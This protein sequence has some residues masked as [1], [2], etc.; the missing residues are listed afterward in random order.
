MSLQQRMEEIVS[1]SYRLLC[2]RIACRSIRVS[3][4]AALQLHFGTILK[5]VGSLYEFWPTSKFSIDLEKQFTEI[6][7]SK[8]NGK[9]RCDIF[10]TLESQK[11][12]VC[13]AIEL[14]YFPKSEGETTTDNRFAILEDIENIEHYKAHEGP[15]TGY[16]IVFTTNPNYANPN[17]R[18][19]INIGEGQ[20]IT[21]KV[22]CSNNK[23]AVDLKGSYTFHWDSLPGNCYFLN[24]KF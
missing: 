17:T 2:Q 9:A 1:T 20:T 4:E 16:S 21:G 5:D 6:K 22:A 11:E 8:S 3:S 23:Y 15:M 10:L 24:L 14:K 7:T 12:S 19:G 18:S 13:A